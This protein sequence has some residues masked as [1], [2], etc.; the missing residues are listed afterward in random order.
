MTKTESLRSFGE[1]LTVLD[2][3]IPKFTRRCA[4]SGRELQPGEQFCSVL[5]L[6]DR[7]WCG[8]IMRRRR[9]QGP[10]EALGLVESEVPDPKARQVGWAPNDVML[11]YF[12]QL[13][14]QDPDEETKTLSY[15]LTLLMIRRRIFKLET[16]ETGRSGTGGV[17]RL[18]P[19]NETNT[20]F[21]W[22]PPTRNRWP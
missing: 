16:S 1:R 12:Q 19:R 3:E 9:W 14:E 21:R 2:F 6:A 11:H 5:V 18:C 22:R 8:W 4:A 15:V 7:T 20:A 17:D 10:P 13:Q